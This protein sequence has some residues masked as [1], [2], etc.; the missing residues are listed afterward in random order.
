MILIQTQSPTDHPT[1]SPTLRPTLGPLRVR[2]RDDD[3]TVM[4]EISAEMEYSNNTNKTE[5]NEFVRHVTED[6]V[7]NYVDQIINASNNTQI[8]VV[9]SDIESKEYD[10]VLTS[11]YTTNNITAVYLKALFETQLETEIL[12]MTI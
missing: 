8:I 7:N 12:G 5:T 10:I 2:P 9:I 4:L 3:S 1:I 11:N 6:I